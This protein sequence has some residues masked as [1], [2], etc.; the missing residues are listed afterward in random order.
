MFKPILSGKTVESHFLTNT[1]RMNSS[2]DPV[3]DEKIG[4]Y[5]STLKHNPLKRRREESESAEEKSAKITPAHT[6]P[7]NPSSQTKSQR[8][9]KQRATHLEPSKKKKRIEKAQAR[10]IRRKARAKETTDLLEKVEKSSQRTLTKMAE[11]YMYLHMVNE[12]HCV[13]CEGHESKIQEKIREL[14]TSTPEDEAE[15]E[16]IEEMGVET[17]TLGTTGKKNTMNQMLERT[18]EKTEA[19]YKRTEEAIKMLEGI[20]EGMCVQCNE[21]AVAR[22]KETWRSMYN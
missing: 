1:L 16:A 15:E 17:P 22:R 3:G 11:L 4:K 18:L 5:M 12:K 20:Q 8:I 10:S 19:L 2:G 7:P 13:S 21:E 6:T 9:E 14:L